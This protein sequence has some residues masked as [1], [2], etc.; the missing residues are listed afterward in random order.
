MSLLSGLS[1]VSIKSAVFRKILF[2]IIKIGH[3]AA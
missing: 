3:L 2:G 1:F